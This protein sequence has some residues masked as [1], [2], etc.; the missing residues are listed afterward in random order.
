[1]QHARVA[2]R[3]LACSLCSL[4]SS[5]RCQRAFCADFFSGRT[6]ELLSL[7][8]LAPDDHHDSDAEDRVHDGDDGD[9]DGGSGGGGG[10]GLSLSSSE[11]DDDDDDDSDDDCD[12]ET[13]SGSGG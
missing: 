1:M 4:L 10:G 3:S 5:R 12:S 9:D 6:I 7:F 13:S 8:A 11:S 2:A